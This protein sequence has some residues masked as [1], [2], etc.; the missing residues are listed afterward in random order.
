MR[1]FGPGESIALREIWRGRIW[2]ARPAT[3][4]HDRDALVMLYV[5]PP[6]R[7]MC[8]RDPSGSWLRIPR[9]GWVLGERIW[10]GSRALSFAWPGHPHAVLLMWDEAWTPRSWYVNLQEPLRRSSLGF[11]YMDEELDAIVALDGSSWSWKDQEELDETVRR[12]NLSPER[13]R[14]LPAEGE[15]LIRRV[16]NGERP[17]DR[18]WTTWRPDPAWT[19][20]VLPD[21]WDHVGA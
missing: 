8:P 5:A 16:L 7:W 19:L 4:V 3:V 11:D 18:D 20:P 12:G 6:M 9:D 15:A 14:A 10:E 17:F 21:G 1:G 13:A 2:S